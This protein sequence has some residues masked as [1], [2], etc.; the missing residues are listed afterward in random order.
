MR[1]SGAN[2][3]PARIIMS[4][5]LQTGVLLLNA[6]VLA[7][8]IGVTRIFSVTMFY[9][10]AFMAIGVA[11]FGFGAAGVV[12]YIAHKR[13]EHVDLGKATGWLSILAGL[14]ATACCMS[15]S[16]PISIRTANTRNNR[17]SCSK[18]ISRL[19][20]RFSSPDS[21][22][23]SYSSNC[24]EIS[25]L[26]LMS[27]VGSALGAVITIPILQWAGEPGA[28]I[29]VA[30]IAFFAAAC[31]YF[32]DA[33][34][35][36]AGGLVVII[37]GIALATLGFMNQT[38]ELVRIVHAKGYAIP[39]EQIIYDRWNAFSRIVVLKG[40]DPNQYYAGGIQN[41]GVSS[42]WNQ[43]EHPL[44]DQYWLLID[45]TAGTPITHYTGNPDEIE[46]A[47]YDVTA[48]AHYL[49]NQP[50]VLVV[51]PGGGKD[52]LAAIA[53]GAKK[54]D[55]A[56]INPLI[57]DII[58][59][60]FKDFD[61]NLYDRPPVNVTISEG[62]TFIA[63][64]REKYDL[65]QISLIDTWAAASTGAY[66]LSENNLYT[67]EAFEQYFKHLAPDGIFSMSR[68]EFEPP[69]ET[70]KVVALAR[71]ALK[72]QGVDDPSQSII[73]IKQGEIANVMIRPS[74]FDQAAIDT[75]K[76]NV[77]RLGY[78]IL[79]MP[80][81]TVEGAGDTSWFY[82][83]LPHAANQQK[84]LG[85]H[86]SQWYYH[87]LITTNDPARFIDTYPLDIRP[88]SDDRPFFFYLM[89]PWQFM[90]ALEFGKANAQLA[91]YNSIAV[92]TLVALLLISIVV[93]LIFII[94]PLLLFQRQDIRERSGPKLKILGYFI[95]LG[96]AYIL[97]EIAL[98][99]HF[100]LFLGYPIYSLVAVLTSLL[101]FSGL[102]S[103]WSGRV[104]NDKLESGIRSAV[105]G[106]GVVAIIYILA[107]PPLFGAMITLPDSV[108]IAIAIILVFPLGWFMGNRSRSDFD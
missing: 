8:E 44:P 2:P 55:G 9:H 30:S 16:R 3:P 106:I 5:P 89:P 28:I 96:L 35:K 29:V 21:R 63:R 102:G 75:M 45:N 67:V 62:R 70:L 47:R 22:F 6:F 82:Q 104:L 101:L 57:G 92:F 83:D 10:F 84:A 56:E 74:G 58:R 54:I 65:I 7:L 98:M 50:N 64:S 31:F 87:E 37:L 32:S 91:G 76:S 17:W 90:K 72:R 48:A 71:D 85:S 14:T 26:Y 88:T 105:I 86:P 52:L 93:V 68:F 41:F 103:G 4:R 13:F 18:F 49:L 36:Q 94:L 97:I 95:G 46:I 59:H 60:T 39:L 69:R 42:A 61:G 53:F 80:G 79:Y 1:P 24:R 73:V 40:T 99:Q 81:A 77:D 108:R 51:G 34:P 43:T 11:L 19:Q 23:R 27:L 38:L 12:L 15:R 66:A 78:K 20:S 25:R 100:T 107:L 33:R